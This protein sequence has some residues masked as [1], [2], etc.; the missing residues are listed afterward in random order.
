[1]P[2]GRSIQFHF[3]EFRD[4]DT[5][6][7]VTRLSPPDVACPRNYFYQKCFT[8][9]GRKLHF[10]GEFD[11]VFNIWML[12]LNT[13]LARQITEGTGDNYHGAYLSPDDQY[14]F[15]TK[16]GR[17]HRRVD[18]ATLEEKI[19]YTVPPEW[20]GAGTWVPNSACTHIAAMEI[21]QADVVTGVSGWER[22]RKQFE[23]N[24]RQRL[25]DID[26][27]TGEARVVLDQRRHMGHP[28]FRP[29]DDSIMGFCHEGPHDLVDARMWFINSDGTNLRKVKEHAPHESCMHEFW[30]PDGSRLMYVSYTKGDQDRFIGAADP[31]TLV[32]ENIMAMPPCAHL[33]SN[34]NGSLLVGDGAGQL[35]DVADKDGHAFEADP[36][37]HLFDMASRSHRK[38]CRHDSTWAEYKGNTQATHPHPSFTPDEKQVLFGSD[39]EGKP[40]LYLADLPN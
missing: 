14:L 18:L 13:G 3:Q 15:Y 19:I 32:N 22:F 12:D 4:P 37:I 38:I 27:A 23:V 39:R 35:G 28:M 29:F 25:M 9:D 16:S 26:I 20:K 34:F 5:G 36:Y 33:M 24:P 10:G 40:G 8:N 17:E 2:K 7:R 30:V 31:V 1:M 11:G 6:V 21:L